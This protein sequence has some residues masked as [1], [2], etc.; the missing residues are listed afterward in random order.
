MSANTGDARGQHFLTI[1]R[2]AALVALLLPLF[3]V[4]VTVQAQNTF[5]SGSTGSDG[6]FSPAT[7]QSIVVP[8][9]GVFNFTTVNIPTGVTITFTRNLTNK[10][11]T[12]LASGDVVI[13]GT[14][15]L[16]GKL[17]NANGGG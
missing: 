2:W 4:A 3:S 11:M 12:I 8:D 7:S 15:N 6:P 14:I 16:D 5:S 13:A 1:K 10:P 17:G 9:S